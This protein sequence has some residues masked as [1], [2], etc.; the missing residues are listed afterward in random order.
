MIYFTS[1][2]HV[3]H[4]N[5]IKYSHRG[6]GTY[7]ERKADPALIFKSVQDM[8]RVMLE[9]WNEIVQPDDTVH[10]IGDFAM[11]NKYAAIDF[12]KQLNGT[13]HLTF[14]NHDCTDF[15]KKKLHPAIEQ[16]GFA[17]IEYE[18]YIEVDGKHLW[19]AHIP[20]GHDNDRR[21]YQRP[22]VKPGFSLKKDI[23]LSAHVHDKWFW[24]DYRSI[25][26][27]CDLQD[28][29]PRTLSQLLARTDEEPQFDSSVYLE[30]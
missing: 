21:A 30:V 23:I 8:N 13:I 29:Y 16:C 22:P 12:F 19:L 14:G 25:N 20:Y 24:N 11:G 2:I 4:E 18:R 1:D 3:N 26:V 27:G 6:Y 9:R 5:I 15:E 28:F 10:L 7:Q 17:S